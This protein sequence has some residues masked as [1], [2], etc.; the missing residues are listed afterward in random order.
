M[1]K[2]MLK[3]NDTKYI[4]LKKKNGVKN[5][6]LLLFCLAMFGSVVYFSGVFSGVLKVA[7]FSF[8]F[9][10]KK[11]SVNEHSYYAVTMGKYE[12]EQEAQA[13][14]S[15]VS[16][17]GA[18]AYV[19]LNDDYYYVIGNVYDNKTDAEKVLTNVSGNNYNVEIKEIKFN[20]ISFDNENFTKEQKQVIL[21]SINNISDVY[22]KCYNYSIKFDQGE[23]VSTV[24]SSELNTLKGDTTIWASKLDAINSV[25][26]T[27]E[28]LLIKNAYLSISQELDAVVLKVIN[29]SSANKDLKYLTTSIAIIKFNMFNSINNL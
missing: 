4:K 19:W 7:N 17:M 10:D 1:S 27:N 15:G 21:E 12:T 9:G 3:Y 24:V 22:K 25:A 8:L 20:K 14:A 23:I 26:V 28:T 18:G 13:V 6:F 5:F 29:G 16:I 11:I 2:K